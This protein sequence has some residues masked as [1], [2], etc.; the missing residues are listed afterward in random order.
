ML[1]MFVYHM[2]HHPEV[3]VCAQVEIDRVVGTQRLPD[4]GDR[5]S[6]PYIDALVRGTLRCHPI[7]PIAIPHAPTEDDVYEG[8][9]I[10]KGTTVMANIWKGGHYIPAG[11]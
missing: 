2:M 11:I 9:R 7:L 1:L 3:Q 5:P 10:P 4:F 8:C 6:L